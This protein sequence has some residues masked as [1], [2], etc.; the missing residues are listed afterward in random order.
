M[1]RF[2]PRHGRFLAA[3]ALGALIAFVAWVQGLSPAFALLSGVNAFFVLYLGLMALRIRSLTAAELRRHAAAADEGVALILFLT[4][5]AVLASLTAIA[6]VLNAGSGGRAQIGALI[7][8][9]LGW[10]ALHVLAAL[11]YA[12]LHY[13]GAQPGMVFPGLGEPEALDFLYASF[14]IGMTAQVSDVQVQTRA[15][16]QAVLVHAVA[17]F[18]YNTCILALAVNAVLTV[19]L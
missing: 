17:S 7:G 8:L 18:F 6:V 15:M 4:A 3:F 5:L 2:H 13:R 19:G 10:A 16:R 9:P 11:H 1:I 12:H 14:T